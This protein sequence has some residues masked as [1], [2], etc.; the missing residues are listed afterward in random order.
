ML[1][2]IYNWHWLKIPVLIKNLCRG[3]KMQ[4]TE[5][6]GDGKGRGGGGERERERFL[7]NF[8]C[9]SATFFSF[10]IASLYIFFGAQIVFFC[11]V[12]SCKLLFLY[13]LLPPIPP[14]PQPLPR[15]E[16]AGPQW[17]SSVLQ[18]FNSLNLLIFTF[19]YVVQYNVVQIPSQCSATQL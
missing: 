11:L 10:P 19:A 18:I 15:E 7:C 2:F 17:N 8:F 3:R 1:V 9:H 4:G 16:V 6:A 5:N 14:P 12:Q 13:F